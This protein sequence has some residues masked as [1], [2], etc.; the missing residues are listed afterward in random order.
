MIKQLSFASAFIAFV[1]T[2]FVQATDI[3]NVFQSFDSLTWQNGANYRYRTPAAPSWI[4]QLSW[5]IL[6]SNVKPGDTFTLNMPCV[7]KFTTSQKTVDL[8][9]GGTVYATCQFAPGDLVVA[10]SQLKCTASDNVK[11]STDATGTV[12]FPFT[13]NVGGS[14]GAVD[15]Q[16]S[17]CFTPGTNEVT[18]TDGDKKLT[19]IA[20]FQGGSNTNTGSTEDIVYSNRLVPTLNKQQLYLLGGTCPNGY[21]RGTLGITTVGGTF[22][23]SSIHSAITNN[24]NEWFLPEVVETILAT[25]RCNGQSY[26]INYDNIPAGY[27][28]FIDI[29][30]SRPVGQVLRTTY[31]NRF[32]CAGSLT[33]TDRSLSVT[34]AEYRNNEAGANGNEVVVTTS[35]WLGSTTAVTTL[36]FNTEPGNTKTILVEVPIPTTT[37]TSS[38]T[39][40]STWTTTITATPGETA[41]QSRL[42]MFSKALIV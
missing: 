37:V 3:S 21:R 26:T 5:H 24:L 38:Y 2:T 18:F 39:G 30:I 11:D 34:W 22:D 31:T 36:P 23:C 33:T 42:A 16:N 12:R 6:G 13:F 10:Y 1:L 29:L 32:Q 19:V 27:R 20:N 8:K 9:V 17:K 4:A 7:F 35:T 41:T 40:Y 15:L 28:P 14:A 25:S